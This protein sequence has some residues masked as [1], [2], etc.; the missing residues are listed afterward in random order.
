MLNSSI[1]NIENAKNFARDYVANT[2]D[3][4]VEIG[5][6]IF[7][8]EFGMARN[9]WENEGKEYLYLSSASTSNKDGFFQTIIGAAVAKFKDPQAAYVGTCPWAY[10][11]VY[12][13][14]TQQADQFGM[15]WAGDPPHESPG[16]YDL[17]DTDETMNIIYRQQQEIEAFLGGEQGE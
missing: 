5:K 6:P 9:N 11:G 3:W 2:S 10:G 4:S 15:V 14:E 12:R 13:P 8:E 16:W 1:S 7:L 17:Y